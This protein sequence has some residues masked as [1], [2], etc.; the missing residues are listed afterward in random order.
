M[1]ARVFAMPDLGEGL[2]EGEI[3]SWLVA[4]GDEIELNQPLVE[5]ETAKATVEIPSPFAGTIEKLHA[6]A[7]DAVAVGAPLVTFHVLGGAAAENRG[8]ERRP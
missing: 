3:V 6:G 7:G 8:E 5:V 2:G 1:A 4:E